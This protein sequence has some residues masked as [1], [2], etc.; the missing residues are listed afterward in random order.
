ML[1]ITSAIRPVPFHRNEGH[2]KSEQV[3]LVQQMWRTGPWSIY[4][5]A[6]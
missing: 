3:M 5:I 6:L 1:Q 2:V 4:I